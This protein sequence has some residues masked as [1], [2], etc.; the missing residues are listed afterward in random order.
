MQAF[1]HEQ[2]VPRHRM[3]GSMALLLVVFVDCS[4]PDVEIPHNLS[5]KGKPL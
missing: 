1:A 4:D 3:T 2:R 5:E